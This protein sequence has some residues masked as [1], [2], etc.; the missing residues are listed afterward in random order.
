MAYWASGDLEA[1]N[2]VF[3]DYT[4]KLRTAGN[5]PDA[6]STSVVLAEIRLALGRL[7]GAIH[8][9]EKLLQFVMHRGEPIYPDTADLHRELSELYLEQ[10]HLEAA[11]QHLQRSKELG[12][13]AELP[14]WRYRWC[15]AQARLKETQ[16]DLDGALA[17]FDEAERLYIRTP[18]PEMG[19]IA[20]MKA[21]IWVTQGKLTQALEWVREQGLSPDTDICY[22][23]EFEHLTL[24]RILIAHYQNDRMENSIH[25]A[26]ELLARLL[27]AAEEGGRYGSLIE[28]LILQS[29]AHQAQGNLPLALAVLERALTLAEPEGYVRIFV[30]EGE[31]M[32][33]LTLALAPERSAG[34][35]VADFRFSIETKS[36][37]QAR[38]LIGYV[39]NLLA[40]FSQPAAMP[41][42]TIKN[43]PSAIVE[44]LSPRELEVLRLL[45]TELSGPEIACELVVSLNTLR[46]HTKNIF[47]K[48]GVNNRRAAVLRAEELGL[49]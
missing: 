43:Q 42:S 1:A 29:L 41:Q 31:P 40:A 32:R 18:L 36:R 35:S 11:A 33:L 13:K 23:R 48:L 22:L 2:R 45:R 39:D 6:I 49:F 20:A 30:D 44:P 10:G 28:I 26:L 12:E 24:A 8:T 3:A 7:H 19:P 38:K 46:T 15:I 37:D 16:G 21:R 47:S 34:A 9:I 5:I 25:A 17:L 4:L 14:V 27:S